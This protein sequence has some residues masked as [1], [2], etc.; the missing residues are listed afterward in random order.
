MRLSNSFFYTMREDSK[1]EDSKSGNILVKSGYIK[2]AS[3]GT[4]MY[5]PL[6][7]KVLKNIESIVRDE[8]VKAGSSEVLMPSLVH[9][10]VYQASGRA[11]AFGSSIFRLKDRFSKPYIL[12]PTHEELFTLTAKM[13]VKSYKDLPFNIFQMQTKFRDEPRPRYGLIRVREFTMKDAYSFDRDLEG[14][15]KAYDIMFEAYKKIFDRCGVDYKIVKS[16]TGAMGGLLSEE[17]QAVT[18]IG[19]DVLVLC[20]SC[21][22]ASNLEIAECVSTKNETASETGKY[23]ELETPKA[24][25][26]DKLA[27]LTGKKANEL[28]KCMIVKADD[29]LVACI[30]AGDK[31][32]NDVKLAKL[33]GANE[34]ALPE[35]EEIESCTNAVIGYAGPV[36]LNIKVIVDTEVLAMR[37][38]IT[39]ANKADYHLEN[40]NIS[41]FEI[42]NS[43]DII[44]IK[45]GDT[46]PK[47]GK[48]VHFKSGIEIGNTFKLG[49]KYSEALGLEYADKDNKLSPVWMGSYGIGTGRILASL[50]EQTADDK[51]LVWPIEIAPYKVTIVRISDKDEMQIEI[52]DKLYKELTASGIET[53]LDDRKTRAGVKFNDA[54]L[55]GIPIRITV[56]KKVTDNQVEVKLRSSNEVNLVNLDELS[57]FI[58]KAI[59]K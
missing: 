8:M 21:D 37:N 22:Y 38:F 36:G 48:T 1:V 4:Y 12:G 55:I 27:K 23:N 43:G 46:C 9:E 54:D 56:G 41:D 7:L 3:V 2:K 28:A 10:E 33:I 16:D 26:I 18:D 42:S 59:S 30:I 35:K 32:L 47:C 11:E 20:D 25:T 15:D 6:G 40:V 51:G 19:E 45:E 5:M 31:E 58:K 29:E 34:I 17:F 24:N 14:L 50:V 52:A 49:T 39:G 57:N 13:A 44:N 53:I